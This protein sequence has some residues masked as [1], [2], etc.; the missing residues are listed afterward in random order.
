M[1]SELTDEALTG[2]LK[3]N[4]PLALETLFSRYYKPL[5][6]FCS[7]Y[8]REYVIAE[9]I[10]ANL[11]IKL[12][13]SRQHAA[14]LNIKSYLF[15]SAK[16]QAFNYNQKKKE[17]VD[18]IE[19]LNI[20]QS[21]LQDKNNPFKILS[22]RESYNCILNLIDTL[23][24]GQRRILMM[25]HIDSLDNR[26]ISDILGISVRTVDT[27]LYKSIRKLRLLLKDFRNSTL[28]T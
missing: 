7:V 6:Q 12:W 16:N 4:D 9:E 19:D 5:C 3:K 14:I 8:T 10:I 11:F 13:D 1:Y 27:T 28:G 22:S 17:P 21:A 18:S 15:V 24:P 2:L 26:Q 23:P 20:N 25:S